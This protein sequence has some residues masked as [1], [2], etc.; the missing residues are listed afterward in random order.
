MLGLT[1]AG[2]R[3]TIRSAMEAAEKVALVENE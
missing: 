1:G 2:E 3:R